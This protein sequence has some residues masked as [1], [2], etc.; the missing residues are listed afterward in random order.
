MARTSIRERSTPVCYSPSDVI[1]ISRLIAALAYAGAA[2]LLGLILGER[3]ELGVVQRIF[4]LV[5]PIAT[6]VMAFVTRGG[7]LNVLLTGAAILGGLLLGQHQWRLAWEE[8]RTR[9][10]HVRT[11][12]LEYHAQHEG[13]PARLEELPIEI[14][15]R[16]GL[17]KTILHYLSNERGF[18]LWMTNDFDAVNFNSSGRS[19]GPRRR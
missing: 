9:G 5:I 10:P 1:L 12:L 4:L 13:Y 7:R 2:F 16:A 14:P 18:R 11:A 15:C 8:C 19:S 17:R 6:L 3:G